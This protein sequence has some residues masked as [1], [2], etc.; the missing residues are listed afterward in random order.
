M[1]PTT[2]I[3]ITATAAGA[4]ATVYAA[5][6]AWWILRQPPGNSK[7]IEIAQAIQEGAAAYMRRQYASIAVVAVILAGLIYFFLGT[8]TAAGF[9]VG[10]VLSSI[11][12][13]IGMYVSV[14]ANVRTAAAASGGLAPALDVAFNGPQIRNIFAHFQ[15]LLFLWLLLRK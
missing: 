12:G 13:F 11:A 9:L 15:V 7:M 8:T 2:L 14:R 4:L 3:L 5:A 10:A 6:L 1:N